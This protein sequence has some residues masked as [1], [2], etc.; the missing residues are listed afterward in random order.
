MFRVVVHLVAVLLS[1]TLV[2]GS[3]SASPQAAAAEAQRSIEQY[4]N[5]AFSA[6]FESMA[7]AVELAPESED[8][9]IDAA[10]LGELAGKPAAELLPY[11][12]QATE[13]ASKRGDYEAVQVYNRKVLKLAELFP[14]WVGERSAAATEKPATE[15]WKSGFDQL[16]AYIQ[17]K[18]F[19]QAVTE[20]ERLKELALEQMGALH[21]ATLDT[22]K[23]LA[24]A[25]YSAGSADKA[26]LELQ[27]AETDAIAA[28]GEQHPETQSI[29][30][31]NGDLQQRSGNYP[32]AAAAFRKARA[33]YDRSLGA[34]HPST[35]DA[36][37][38]L[39]TV[40]ELRGEYDA[41]AEALLI[42]CVAAGRTLSD[43]HIDTG[44]CYRRLG[45]MNFRQGD[46]AKARLAYEK[47]SK[48]IQRVAGTAHP[49]WV[50]TQIYRADLARADAEFAEAEEI[51]GRVTALEEASNSLK[52]EAKG[53][54]AQL[55][56]DQGL[57]PKAEAVIQEI[58][59][60]ETETL[61]ET[62]P[63]AITSLNN[64]AG[65]QRKQSR[66]IEAERGYELALQRFTD[67]MG[68]QHPST[69]AVMNNLA[70]TL[71]TQGLYDRA[72][73]LYRKALKR[74]KEVLGEVHP[75]TIANMN[76]LAM[77]YESQG[78]FDKS[79]PLYKQTIEILEG[80]RGA[81]HP[82]TV[83]VKNNLGYL[84]LLQER[85]E[86]AV[87]LFEEV[88]DVWEATLGEEHQKFMKG[89]N[90]LGRVTHN[91]GDFGAAE[92]M[93]GRALD[94]RIRVMGENHMD[95]LRSQHDLGKLYMDMDRLEE[96]L[97]LLQKTLKQAEQ[98][99]GE[100]HPYTFETLNTLAQLQ[101][102]MAD[103][104]GAFKTMQ[105][106]F[107]RRNIFLD[108]MLWA[109]SENAREGYIRLHRPELNR[110]LAMIA[111][112]ESQQAG[113]E[114]MRV[115]LQ[116]KGLLLQ[117]S[118]QIHQ[119]TKMADEPALT[120]ISDEL[121]QSRKELAALTLSGPT[122]GSAV[123][124][125]EKQHDLKE[126]ISELEGELGRASLRFREASS[127]VSLA[128]LE[129]HLPDDSALVDYMIFRDSEDVS[130]LQVALLK[131]QGGE[132]S[133]DHYLYEDLAAVNSGVSII[134]EV[135]QDEFIGTDE[136]MEVG[137]EVYSTVWSPIAERLG[138]VP[139]VY[140]V[141][142][143]MLNILPFNAM[144]TDG[145]EYLL[146]ALDL[147]SIS[148]SRDIIP[149]EI[150]VAKGG[151]MIMAGPDYDTDEVIG[152]K[153]LAALNGKR[154]AAANNQAMRGMAHGMRGLSFAPLPGAEEE[155]RQIKEQIA[156]AGG[157]EQEAMTQ[158]IQR[159]AAQEELLRTMEPPEVL[160]IS[161]HGFFL[162]PNEE[163]KKRLSKLTRGAGG[164]HVPPPGDNPLMRAG[165]AFAG[166]N[167]NAKLL[168][169]I[170]TDNDGVL[171][172]L[173]ALGLNLTGTRLA[174]L[175]ACETGL[176]EIHEGEGVYGLRRSFQEAG[177]GAVVNS[178]WEVSDAGTQ[179]LMNGLYQR[180]LEGEGVHSAL[181]NTQLE[182]A[183]SDEWAHPYI[184]SAFYMVEGAIGADSGG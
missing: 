44:E 55:L 43:L 136:L 125:L 119:V 49:S 92:E 161:T 76:N 163:L 93:I 46:F 61:G 180:V 22:R 33:A 12:R 18:K 178:L 100:Q 94:L 51:I 26:F 70:L 67:S 9:Q 139:N 54:L 173:E 158:L 147:H 37:Q 87:E 111:E 69:L 108:Q 112:M 132:V 63:N 122:E 129:E 39:A 3:A 127:K 48:I 130:K 72:E 124:F 15:G 60:Y 84:Y 74:S 42:S 79:E 162:K 97:Q 58:L 121:M 52:F 17:Q 140:V 154:S 168:G 28:L 145:E 172:A 16:N 159:K 177:A 170:D 179:A 85:N 113:R 20:G 148:S 36:G 166:L 120:A 164:V 114:L 38:R 156:A 68:E 32:A 146:A 151:Y 143:G 25:L 128:S 135:I 96:S 155:G 171:T 2:G 90:N 105:T 5:K 78:T 138:E 160:H 57:Y 41:A 116:R 6:A 99:L 53:V 118:S 77:L 29:Q 144:V 56:E 133:Y 50:Q 30:M 109:T 89:L 91:L 88:V 103:R 19:A 4:K 107:E 73:P 65:L 59:D 153:M 24:Y 102:K 137:M 115:S 149:S 117:V 8:Y 157:A 7:R 66:F 47:S 104:E 175:S 86:D 123:S 64:L 21:P 14:S 165:L 75:T 11:Y 34:G 71:E 83:A 31:L 106:T 82:D 131:K 169:E 174:I 182:M 80:E 181:R 152:K 176:G 45:L 62:H 35:L 141:P 150:P 184:W 98:N 126:R 142:D 81:S 27:Q 101:L 95:T 110:Y 183:Q 10:I 40:E 1:A 13:L 134:R 23:K 167:A